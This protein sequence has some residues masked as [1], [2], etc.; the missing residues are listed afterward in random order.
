M[1]V[2]HVARRLLPWGKGEDD[3]TLIHAVAQG[4]KQALQALYRA[5][6]PR[7]VR[8]LS[9]HV[10]RE[11]LAEEVINDCFWVVW[12]QAG[13]FR[14]GSRVS[15]WIFGIAYRLT[16]K[17]LRDRGDEPLAD[18][19]GDDHH[20]A[21]DTDAQREQQDWLNKGLATLTE[22]QR[23]ALQLAYEQGLDMEEIAEVMACSVSAVKSRLFHART[24]LRHV[25]PQIANPGQAA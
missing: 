19:E 13:Q 2:L 5:Y 20:T 3:D 22:E 24:K 9:R 7:L 4:D 25:L 14:G 10:R 18:P 15:T 16:M 12:Q 17:A 23:V 6:H 11:D 8:F 21:C 1:S